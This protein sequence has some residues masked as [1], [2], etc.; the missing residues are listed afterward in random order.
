MDAETLVMTGLAH[1]RDEDRAPVS[2]DISHGGK[3]TMS[4]LVTD[5]VKEAFMEVDE[6]APG[7]WQGWRMWN[8]MVRDDNT[9]MPNPICRADGIGYEPPKMSWN[10]YDSSSVYVVDPVQNAAMQIRHSSTVNQNQWN[11][12]GYTQW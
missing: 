2:P 11:L 5:A 9:T 10:A 1:G 4:H 6:E 3:P 12:T 7:G 8:E